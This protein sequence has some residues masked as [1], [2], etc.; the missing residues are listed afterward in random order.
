MDIDIIYRIVK[1]IYGLALLNTQEI[2]FESTPPKIRNS[3]AYVY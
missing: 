2:D 3:I 1:S